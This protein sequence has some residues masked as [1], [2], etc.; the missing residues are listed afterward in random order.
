MKEHIKL[1]TKKNLRRN[2][3]FIV[4]IFLKIYTNSAMVTALRLV[5][6]KGGSMRE[7]GGNEDGKYHIEKYMFHQHKRLLKIYIKSI[8]TLDNYDFIEHFTLL[9]HVSYS[10]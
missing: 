4:T 3:C 10:S 8:S 9:F 5:Q 1:E 2:I 7:L 6:M